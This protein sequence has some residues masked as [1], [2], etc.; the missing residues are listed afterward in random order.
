[1]NDEL[2]TPLFFRVGKPSRHHTSTQRRRDAEPSHHRNVATSQPRKHKDEARQGNAELAS[3]GR[4]GFDIVPDRPPGFAAF[5]AQCL[6]GLPRRARCGLLSRLRDRPPA[7]HRCGRSPP[8]QPTSDHAD[9]A[10]LGRW[11]ANASRRPRRPGMRNTGT[12]APQIT[13]DASY[14]GLPRSLRGSFDSLADSF[15]QGDIGGG[16]AGTV[17]ASGIGIGIGYGIGIGIG[18]G[19][20]YGRGR[21]VESSP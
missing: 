13:R 5:P 21:K 20:G 4:A 14:N 9:G 3:T 16:D 6:T 19:R 11:D 10:T 7:C 2:W 17:A 1:M 8:N 18:H 15:A 12:Q